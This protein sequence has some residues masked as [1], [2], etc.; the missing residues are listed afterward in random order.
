MTGT[1]KLEIP[2]SARF[3]TV[4]RKTVEEVAA[5]TR[6]TTEQIEELKLAVGEACSNAVKYGTKDDDL[7]RVECRI[8]DDRMEVDVQNMGEPFEIPA[9]APVEA[10]VDK[11][12]EG[13]LG[14][15]LI[16]KVMD[17]WS[18]CSDSGKTIVKLVK[19]FNK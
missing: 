19:R 9:G 8:K 1:I 12:S 6:L 14:I 10:P 17:G 11:L 4:A 3:I 5:R 2:N 7:V 18:I 15:Y 13:G 16:D